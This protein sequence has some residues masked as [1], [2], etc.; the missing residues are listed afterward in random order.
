MEKE[1]KCKLWNDRGLNQAVFVFLGLSH[2][3]MI[4]CNP[5]KISDRSSLE[6]NYASSSRLV[7][8]E[9]LK[10]TVNPNT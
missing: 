4:M 10:S 8:F 7:L 9:G 5:S 2:I 3:L 1:Q 6:G